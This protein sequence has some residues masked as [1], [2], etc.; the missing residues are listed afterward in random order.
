MSQH[1]L[2]T[3]ELPDL[4]QAMDGTAQQALMMVSV[5]EAIRTRTAHKLLLVQVRTVAALSRASR[6]PPLPCSFHP[7][8]CWHGSSRASKYLTAP[9]EPRGVVIP[10]CAILSSQAA[11][12]VP[13]GGVDGAMIE[14]RLTEDDLAGVVRA[15]LK[16][17]FALP[18][19]QVQLPPASVR[20]SRGHPFFMRG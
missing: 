10:V 1:L 3:P 17:L 7:W 8:G 15:A 2:L 9:D 11:G 4:T 5:A 19:C 16:P 6:H 13:L 12:P 14:P 20:A 18:T